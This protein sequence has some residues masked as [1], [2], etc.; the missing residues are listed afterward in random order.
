MN[1]YLL[2]TTY[3]ICAYDDQ[4]KKEKKKKKE[5]AYQYTKYFLTSQYEEICKISRILSKC[6]KFICAAR[7][8][9]YKTLTVM[10]LIVQSKESQGKPQVWTKST[11]S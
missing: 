11:C 10:L 4:K 7:Y 2:L 6:V 5:M 8:K 9:Y 3:L 1:L